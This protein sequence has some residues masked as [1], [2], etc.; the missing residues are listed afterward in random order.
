MSKAKLYTLTGFLGSGKTT[1]LTS[2]LNNVDGKK[3]GVI[4]NEFG[5]IGIDGNIIKKDGMELIEINRGSIFCSC[6]KLSFIESLKEMS[7]REIE[8]LFVE[9]SGLADPSNMGEILAALDVLKKDAVEFK[10]SIVV[11]DAVNFLDQLEDIE[12]VTRQIKHSQIAIISKADLVDENK[13]GNVK[14]TIRSIN[15][16]IRI[17][18]ADFGSIDFDFFD[19][20]IFKYS[21]VLSEESTNVPENKPKSISLTF[22]KSVKKDKLTDFINTVKKDC[23]RIK[24]F[25]EL[26]DGWY[27]VDVV[28]DLIDYKKIN[29]R[30]DQ[31]QLV[32]IS[33]I[34]PQIIRPVFNNWT[35]IIK[36]KMVLR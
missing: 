19:E 7:D 31:S 36:E 22:D 25:F 1:F 9:G 12:T 16:N 24:G 34:G 13:L 33:K 35:E 2:L 5:K 18:I 20:D 4:Q 11:V 30:N 8:Y 26:E 3:V 28:N 6:L 17:E 15:E 10:G 32:F 27:Q 14:A 21:R 23:F 29:S